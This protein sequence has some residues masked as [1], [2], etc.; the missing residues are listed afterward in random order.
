MSSKWASPFPGRVQTSASV[1]SGSVVYVGAFSTPTWC[2][3]PRPVVGDTDLLVVVFAVGVQRKLETF[4]MR[5]ERK[6]RDVLKTNDVSTV[7]V[8]SVKLKL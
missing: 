2:T 7:E 6:R 5:S 1:G 8:V 4:H 3:C